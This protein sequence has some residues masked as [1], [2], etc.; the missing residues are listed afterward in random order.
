MKIDTY[1]ADPHSPRQRGSN[2][3]TNRLL[4]QYLPKGTDLST[5]SQ[6][7]LG[8]IAWQ[9]STQPRKA[10]D[11]LMPIEAYQKALDELQSNRGT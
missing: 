2:E 4:P 9:I 7:D 10:L 11:F 3:N 1:F 6:D 8:R 5:L